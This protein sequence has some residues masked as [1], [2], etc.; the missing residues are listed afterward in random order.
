MLQKLRF[1]LALSFFSVLSVGL[2]HSQDAFITTWN[3]ENPGLSSENAIR[4]PLNNLSGTLFYNFTVNWGDG[5]VEDYTGPLLQ[6][7][8]FY[9]EPGIYEVSI[10][11]EF[12]AVFFDNQGDRLKLLTIEQWGAIAWSSFENAF[13]GCENLEINTQD[14]PILTGVSSMASAFSGC[15]VLNSPVNDWDVS[16]VTDFRST[17]E[18][19]Y[20]FNQSLD[21]WDVSNATTL[22]AMF[23]NASV[24]NGDITTWETGNVTDLGRTFEGAFN[25]NQDISSWD[26]SQV[27]IFSYTFSGAGAFNQDLSTW[28]TSSATEMNFMFNSATIFNQPIDSWDVSN[29]TNFRNMFSLA[30]AFNQDLNSWETGN[31]TDMAWM[32]RFAS[33]FDG[34][35]SAW[36][37]SSVTDMNHMFSG[38]TSFNQDLSAWDVS[39]VTSTRS[40][41]A[42]AVNFD[43]DLGAWD[44]S[45]VTTMWS[46]FHEATVF[47]QDIGQWDVS[48]VENFSWMFSQAQAF[49][50][51][52]SAWDITSGTTLSNIFSLSGLSTCNYDK[53]L[54]AWAELPLQTQV[55]MNAAGIQYTQTAASAREAIIENFSWFIADAGMLDISYDP[56]T[57]EEILV[58]APSCSDT[59]DA[60]IDALISGGVEPLDISWIDA[61][62]T[63]FEGTT[64]HDLEP[65]EYTLTVGD[66]I[67]CFSV[68]ESV[69]VVAPAP[70]SI[71]SLS[72]T[73]PSCH[74]GNDGFIQLSFNG[75]TGELTY[76]WF[77]DDQFFSDEPSIQELTADSYN[78]TVTDE[79]NCTF[80]V[81]FE[82]GQ[83]N[84]III[85]GEVIDNSI[86]VSVSGG[87]GGFTY[88][89]QGPNGFSST[90]SNLNDL[91]PGNYTLV[92]SDE[93]GC[94][95]S[96]T[97]TVEETYVAPSREVETLSIYPNPANASVTVDLSSARQGVIMIYNSAGE[98]V[99]AVPMNGLLPVIEVSDLS[100]GWYLLILIDLDGRLV[101]KAPVVIQR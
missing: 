8:H 41:F 87:A 13:Y 97:F 56:L 16:N 27:S 46:M 99:K 28:N 33:A 81:S 64:L 12:P 80:N 84:E 89:W 83:P 74:G 91:D 59:N 39:N 31:V 48:N 52:L 101:S 43:Q 51:D 53:V 70:L 76:E 23:R 14:N 7:T 78:L 95:A 96:S 2:L 36:N 100:A 58:T 71:G 1:T 50:Q 19:C 72:T 26:V 66:E 29:V 82:L 38:A 32:F 30:Q 40:M 21:E 47:N 65:G 55:A 44:V 49:D 88:A 85:S 92:V 54:M 73:N 25:F 77:V 35:I 10:E 37:T 60:S 9:E 62:G 34:D 90:D 4:I 69:S 98:M 68:V 20:Q 63:L 11:G 42:Q 6:I 18:N 24:F 94:T 17:F 3:T 61:N 45:A 67:G 22:R 75:G 5:E 57:I 15:Q 86:S 93:N 79:N